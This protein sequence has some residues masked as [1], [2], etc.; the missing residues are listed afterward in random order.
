MENKI[1]AEFNE[2]ET[3]LIND[4]LTIQTALKPNPKLGG[5][6]FIL[7]LDHNKYISRILTAFMSEQSEDYKKTYLDALR[8]NNNIELQLSNPFYKKFQ[9]GKVRILTETLETIQSDFIK[10]CN[11]Y[12]IE[13]NEKKELKVK[14]DKQIGDVFTQAISIYQEAEKKIQT[15]LSDKT[16]IRQAHKQGLRVVDT[17]LTEYKNFV[18]TLK[19][20]DNHLVQYVNK[21]ITK[22]MFR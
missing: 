10:W 1:F 21:M 16:L 13:Q 17:E 18:K 14:L 2:M 22:E 6:I 7:W 15:L 12:L 8:F 9:D 20:Q 4:E 11:N 3:L 5:D 19:S